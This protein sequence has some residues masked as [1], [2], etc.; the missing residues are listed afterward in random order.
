[1]TA[2]SLMQHPP[3]AMQDIYQLALAATSRLKMRATSLLAEGDH[4]SVFEACV[5]FHEAARG[6][7]RAVDALP[8][9]PPEGRLAA[10][11]EECWCLLEGRDPQRA[12]DAWGRVLRDRQTLDATTAE[13]MLARLEPFFRT[14][15]EEFARVLSCC[16]HLAALRAANTFVPATAQAQKDALREVI[17]VLDAFP[18][19]I[20]F[21]WWR[22]RLTDALGKS[23]EAWGALT[24]ARRLDPENRRFEAMS[25][26]LAAHTFP[27]QEADVYLAR[28]RGSLAGAGPEVCLMYALAEVEI[29]KKD[30]AP[31]DRWR[32]AQEAVQVG[33][34][35][36]PSP[37]IGRSLTAARLLLDA[38][39]AGRE[40]TL[41]IFYQAGLGERAVTAPPRQGVIELL[42]ALGSSQVAANDAPPRAA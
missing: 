37:E 4:D 38:L 14:K 22:Y 29:G 2:V 15:L 9:F 20:G 21:W 16:A 6:E 8:G 36:L 26:L 19:L 10:A 34:S 33:L 32:R 3:P 31:L 39:Q 23:K 30:P 35:S 41:D 42:I 5:L 18:G 27:A 17:G 12:A 25:L 1:M 28:A 11:I 24:R 7:R 13:A 40:P